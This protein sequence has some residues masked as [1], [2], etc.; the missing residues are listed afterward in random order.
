MT[1]ELTHASQDCEG[2]LFCIKALFLDALAYS[3]SKDPD[4]MYMHQAMEVPDKDKFIAAMVEEMDAQLK[5]FNFSLILRSKVPKGA[6]ILLAVWQMKRKRRIQTWEVYKWKACLN[7]D[8]S[9]QVKGRDYWDTYAPV[10]TWGSI[11]LVLAKAII[12]GW[13][14]KQIDF[15]MAY[16]QASVERDMY[17]EIPKGFEVEGDGDYVL[18]IHKNIY[19]QKQAGCVSNKHLVSRLKSIKFH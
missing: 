13:H 1:T 19:G 5:G 10:A 7:I 11:W 4:T 14:S 8:S 3:A 16:T 6:T 18:Q 15:V 9:R 2:E 17:M 12:Q